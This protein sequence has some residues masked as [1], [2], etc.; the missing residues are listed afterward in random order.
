MKHTTTFDGLSFEDFASGEYVMYADVNDPFQEKIHV[1]QGHYNRKAGIYGIAIRRNATVNPQ[2][3]YDTVKLISPQMLAPHDISRSNKAT[4][5]YGCNHSNSKGTS[6]ASLIA[7][8]G[9]TGYE[10]PN[11]VIITRANG[12]QYQIKTPS[13]LAMV[14]DSFYNDEVQFFNTYLAFK[15]EAGAASIKG[16]CGNFNGKKDDDETTMPVFGGMNSV[17]DGAQMPSVSHNGVKSKSLFSQCASEQVNPITYAEGE[18]KAKLISVAAQRYSNAM[19]GGEGASAMAHSLAVLTDKSAVEGTKA[20]EARQY[21]LQ[22]RQQVIEEMERARA[23]NDDFG[24]QKTLAYWASNSGFVFA[25]NACS[26][27]CEGKYQNPPSARKAMNPT[28]FKEP[29]NSFC[30]ACII[31]QCSQME[32]V[33]GPSTV[34]GNIA[35]CAASVKKFTDRL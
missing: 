15:G 31:D 21:C 25:W 27:V 22:H 5:Q 18:T 20:I 11:G 23:D 12:Y 26:K 13:G 24:Y 35:R 30:R 29:K 32:A 8:A 14:V 34:Q 16:Y 1:L 28:D 17:F 6:Y 33:E 3:S 19:G 9:P 10:F 4:V 2:G 7:K